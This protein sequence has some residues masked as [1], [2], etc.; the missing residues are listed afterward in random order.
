MPSLLLLLL[1]SGAGLAKLVIEESRLEELSVEMIRAEAELLE[2][3]EHNTTFRDSPCEGVTETHSVYE[4]WISVEGKE[5]E[6]DT[7]ELVV[8]NHQVLTHSITNEKETWITGNVTNRPDLN[9]MEPD[10]SS[11][12]SAL[13]EHILRPPS[14]EG[15]NRTM[16]PLPDPTN[17]STNYYSQHGQDEFLEAFIFKKKV[18]NGFFVEA[19]AVDCVLDSN[20]LAFETLY[21]WTGLLVEANPGMFPKGFLSGRQAWQA[22]VCLAT[23]DHAHFAPFSNARQIKGGMAGLAPEGTDAALNGTKIQCFPLYSLLLALETSTVNLFSLDI[24]GAEFEVL[25]VFPW[26]KV[27]VEVM[28][29]ELEHAGKVFPGTRREVHQFLISKGYDYVG[30]LFEDDI[31]IL[32]EL[33][34]PERY[35]LEEGQA[36]QLEEDVAEFFYLYDAKKEGLP[37]QEVWDEQE[38]KW[39]AIRAEAEKEVEEKQALEAEE[40]GKDEL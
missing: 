34:V 26:D 1:L 32:Q 23:K 16:I 13:K 22:P 24:E 40:S 28:L 10:S 21:G 31:F 19:G 6:R 3:T 39:L 7:A 12:L 29:V 9:C 8:T 33:N 17:S 11:L 25:K 5:L 30:S 14:S 18:K 4:Y 38:G 35:G 15:Y 27:R 36:D 2:E 20:T 37:S